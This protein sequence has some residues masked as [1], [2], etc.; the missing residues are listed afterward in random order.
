MGQPGPSAP[1]YSHPQPSAPRRPPTLLTLISASFAPRLQS[2]TDSMCSLESSTT[3][4]KVP[5]SCRRHA[6]QG[7]VRASGPGAHGH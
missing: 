1:H 5:W 2:H 6:L 3:H 4:R 7:W